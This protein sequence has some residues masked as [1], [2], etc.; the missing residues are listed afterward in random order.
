MIISELRP[1][2]NSMAKT[3]KKR[4]Y[5]DTSIKL[6]DVAEAYVYTGI[7]T[8]NV[9]GTNP[10]NFVMGEGDILQAGSTY[11]LQTY[12]SGSNTSDSWGIVPVTVRDIAKNPTL[13]FD[14]MAI[15]VKNNGLKM[16]G[17][18]VLTRFGFKFFKRA[19]R[20]P[21]N[22]INRTI[23]KPLGMGVKL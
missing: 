2:L 21:K 23:F 11:N 19:L 12:A 1:R 16:I 7:V 13:A 22:M 6:L 18:T 10:V 17:Q 20:Q 4:S 5:R 14:A 8:Q 9:A 15:N 3:K